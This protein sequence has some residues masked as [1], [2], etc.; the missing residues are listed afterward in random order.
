MPLPNFVDSIEK[1]VIRHI[2]YRGTIRTGEIT[3]DN[4]DETYDV[5]IAM[6]DQSYPSVET[7]YHNDVFQVGEIVTLG[8]EYG[9]KEIPKILGHGKKVAQDPVEVEV[10]YSG[11]AKVDTLNA[12]AITATTAYLEGRIS[13]GGAG[14]CK[15]RGFEYGTTTAYGLNTHTDGSYGD[16]SYALQITSLTHNTT[17]HF[18]AYIIDENNDTIYGDD[19]TFLTIPGYLISCEFNNYKI[20]KHIGISA[21]IETSF[22]SPSGTAFGPTGLTWADGNLISIDEGSDTI[23]KHSGCTSTILDS[24]PTPESDP[25]GLA[26]DGTNIMSADRGLG[27]YKIYKHSGISSGISASIASPDTFISGLTW[28][29]GNLISCD[30]SGAGRIYVHDG[31]SDTILDDFASPDLEPTGLTNDGTNLISCDYASAIIYLHSGIT[32][33]VT[34]S[35]SAPDESCMGLTV[36]YTT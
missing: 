20:Y 22:A 4:G 7:L 21:S 9:S 27:V 11:I 32:S 14:N 36:G 35:F 3:A 13:L 5:K 2:K 25:N 24:F 29:G 33:T 18:R 10:D 15:T 12:Y 31:F 8:F 19:K 30:R 1:N 17:Y 28:I 16:G 6:S 34:D 26:W 23:Y